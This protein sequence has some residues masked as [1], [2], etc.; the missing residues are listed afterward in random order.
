[1]FDGIVAIPAFRSAKPPEGTSVA[2]RLVG[3]DGTD[4]PSRT[5]RS[6]NSPRVDIHDGVASRRPLGRIGR[7]EALVAGRRAFGHADAALHELEIEVAW[8]SE[9]RFSQPAQADKITHLIR[10]SHMG[11]KQP[12]QERELIPPGGRR[13]RAEY[14]RRGE[15]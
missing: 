12:E 2:E 11:S 5:C 8:A 4:V 10:F 9:I 6:Q 15:G 7:F 1:M 14:G 3:V 13:R